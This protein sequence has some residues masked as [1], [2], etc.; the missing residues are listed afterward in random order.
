MATA[1]PTVGR[2]S[3]DD[4]T[5]DVASGPP[6]MQ[7]HPSP[8]LS[9]QAASGTLTAPMAVATGVAGAASQVSGIPIIGTPAP[10][11]TRGMATGASH[12]AAGEPIVVPGSARRPA[13]CRA[14]PECP[15]GS[16][17]RS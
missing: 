15:A 9:P 6:P 12:P 8:R 11:T 3:A 4:T 5:P 17:D 16:R 14:D 1:M 7:T 2:L 13:G 10:V